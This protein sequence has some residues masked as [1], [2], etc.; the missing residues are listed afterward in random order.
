MTVYLSLMASSVVFFGCQLIISL[1]VHYTENCLFFHSLF[2]NLDGFFNTR[3][4]C[5]IF[6][7]NP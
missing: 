3:A 4:R 5:K 7:S 6:H 2:V 1:P